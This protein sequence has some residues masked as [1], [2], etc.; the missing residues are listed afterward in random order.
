ML[1]AE[2]LQYTQHSG[3]AYPR[4]LN[5]DRGLPWAERVLTTWP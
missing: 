4:F 2:L 1:P 3:Q 5:P